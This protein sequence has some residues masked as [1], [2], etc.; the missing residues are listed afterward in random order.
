MT[1]SNKDDDNDGGTV[2]KASA[3]FDPLDLDDAEWG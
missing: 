3:T 2:H 1:N